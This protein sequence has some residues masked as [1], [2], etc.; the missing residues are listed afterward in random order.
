[1]IEFTNG[2]IL[3]A[4][5]EALVNTVNCVG[6]MGR[7]IALQ[8]K[9]RSRRTSRRTSRV[10]A[11]RGAAGSDVRLRDRP[12]HQSEVHHQ[13]PDQAP[14]ARQEPDRGHRSPGSRRWSP[15]SELAESVPIA[16]PPLGSG[17]GGLDW[18]DVR[19]RIEAASRDVP[20]VEVDRLRAERRAGGGDMPST[21]VPK[22]TPGRAA[23][24]GL[25]EPLLGGLM[26]RRDAAR[27][28][29]ADVLHA[30]GRR[31]AS[32]ALLKAPY[33]PLRGEPA[34]CADGIEGHFITGYAT[35]A[36]RRIS[37]WS[38]CPAR[39]RKR[40]HFL[41]ST[42]TH[43]PLRAGRASSSRAS[44]RRSGWNCSRPYTGSQ[45]RKGRVSRSEIRQATYAWGHRKKQFTPDQIDLA[46]DRLESQGWFGLMQPD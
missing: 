33:G 43:E 36:T 6:I 34:A 42:A 32:T 4:D 23:L 5:A 22:M 17:L 18:A 12:A 19:P 9:K 3:E 14:L 40:R 24:V 2:D 21:K 11:R 20:S 35:A 46:V 41:R 13:L 8:F 30:G 1:M 37:S 15:R 26:D 38:W 29:Q 25:I 45:Q 39:S 27:G 28:P 31:A 10:Q 16:I 44:R 7:G